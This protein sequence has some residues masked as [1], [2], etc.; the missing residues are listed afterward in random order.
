MQKAAQNSTGKIKLWEK[1]EIIVGS[2]SDSGKY[3]AR[4]E[5]QSSDGMI[6]STPEFVSGASLLHNGSECSVIVT[7]ED[8]V[9]QFDSTITLIDGPDGRQYV[10]RPPKRLQRVQRRQFVRIDLIKRVSLA[11]LGRKGSI[12]RS[13]DALTWHDTRTVNVSGGGLLITCPTEIEPDDLMLVKVSFFPEVGLPLAVA[14]VCR[15]IQTVKKIKQA[16]IE[17]LRTE[18]LKRHFGAE[19][20]KVL[21]ESVTYFDQTMQNKLVNY[22]FQQQVILRQKGL[23]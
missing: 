8:A 2:G 1:F 4:L 12:V 13:L 18:Q 10:L 5:D 22:V 23:L 16:G 6:I 14:A 3:I 15:R 9:Y 21:P 17:F 11:L 20:Q 7:K 19:D